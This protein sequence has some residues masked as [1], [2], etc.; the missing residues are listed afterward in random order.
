MNRINFATLIC[1]SFFII[2][3][4]AGQQNKQQIEELYKDANAYFDFKE[5]EEALA[6]Y[7]KV[8]NS[9]T[10]NFNRDYTIGFDDLNIPRRKHHAVPYL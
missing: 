7:L 4:A 8:Y 5:Y 3:T 1:L 10:D 2:F 9:H 6:V